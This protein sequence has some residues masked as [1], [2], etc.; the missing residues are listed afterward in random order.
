ML[1]SVGGGSNLSFVYPTGCQ[2]IAEVVYPDPSPCYWFV[3]EG[4]NQGQISSMINFGNPSPVLELLPCEGQNCCQLDYTYSPTTGRY[5]LVNFNPIQVCPGPPPTIITKDITCLDI[6]GNPVTYTGTVTFPHGCESYC[7]SALNT[8]FKTSDIKEFKPLPDF[9]DF[10]L[11]PVPAHDFI[12]FSTTKY[13]S[14]LEIYDVSGKKIIQ[15]S[16]FDSNNIDI[17]NLAEGV[18]F[19]RIY[20]NDTSVRSVKILKH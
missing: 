8:L 6:N 16:I 3:P 14:K 18:H 5:T 17:T 13:I 1:Q 15:Q 11:F 20:F 10:K 12:T 9:I 7:S 4:P 2:T 19:I